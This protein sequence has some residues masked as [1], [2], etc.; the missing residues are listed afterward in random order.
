M[1]GLKVDASFRIFQISPR[2]LSGVGEENSKFTYFL[3]K[4][5]NKA[6]ELEMNFY[7]IKTMTL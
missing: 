2:A 1:I 5:C 6:S 4:F 7:Q 3:F